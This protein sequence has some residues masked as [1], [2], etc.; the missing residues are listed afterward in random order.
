MQEKLHFF[1][2]KRAFLY[3][4][5]PHQPQ[6]GGGNSLIYNQLQQPANG[7]K[8]T[9]P[10]SKFSVTSFPLFRLSNY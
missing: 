7:I 6:R 1:T 4:Q 8:E 5:N 10:A 3:F 2:K 9:A